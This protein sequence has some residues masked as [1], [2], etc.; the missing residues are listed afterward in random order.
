MCL[1]RRANEIGTGARMN[2]YVDLQR[3]TVQS[4]RPVH[5]FDTDNAAKKLL[6]FMFE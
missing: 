5:L 2:V 6:G 3:C 4:V 1:R